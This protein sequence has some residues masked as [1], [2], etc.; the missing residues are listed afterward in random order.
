MPW[1][2]SISD[3]ILLE[4]AA[5][6]IFTNFERVIGYFQPEAMAT[7]NSYPISSNSRTKLNAFRYKDEIVP[8]DAN[9]N[10]PTGSVH[11][12]EGN[13]RSGS[14]GVVE[15]MQTSLEKGNPPPLESHAPETS[16]IKEC[17]QTPGNR[18]PLADLI[19]NAEDSFDPAPGPE[20]TP[21][22]HVIWQ[23]VPASSNPSS[24]TPAGRRRKRGLSSSSAG[25][26]S[27]GNKKKG[28][29]ESLGLHSINAL[30]KTPQH[31]MAAELWNNYIDKNMADGADDLPPPR[32]ANLLSS[33]PQTPASG[34]TNRESS[35]LRRAISCTTEFPST[36]AKRRR[37]NRLDASANRGAFQRTSSNVESGKPKTSRINYLMEK[38]E[39]SIHL[40]PVDMCPPGSSPLRQHMDVRRCRSSSPTKDHTRLE[41]TEDSNESP[42]ANL[43]EKGRSEPVPVLQGSSS[44][45]GDDDLDQ[46]LMDL[47]NA[48]TDPF[49]EPSRASNGVASLGASNWAALAPEKSRSWEPR[50]NLVPDGKLSISHNTTNNEVKHDEFDEFDD[51]YDDLPGNLQEILA[52][53]DQKPDPVNMFNQTTT[54]APAN[55]PNVKNVPANGNIS[56]TKPVGAMSTVKA[57]RVSSDDEFDDDFDME[58]IE[59][60]LKQAGEAGPAYVCHS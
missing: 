25:S 21:V 28:Q 31:D 8:A 30:F 40:A 42:C 16:P 26:P 6:C 46:D 17:P 12:T 55:R 50:N 23:H 59:Q 2:I 56:N 5:E 3:I 57:E 13:L 11:G 39:K 29:K 14:N 15:L 27:N 45:F 7:N 19:S 4:L 41:D 54:G 48:S 1:I 9:S 18:I 10:G 44:D 33:S 51:D 36:R 47:A 60:T 24:Q 53:C 22:E 43:L 52:K 38:I 35:G 58:A 32:L 34:R 20:I 37:V 49:V